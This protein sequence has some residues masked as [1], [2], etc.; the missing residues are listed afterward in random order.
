MNFEASDLAEHS[1]P[2]IS[3]PEHVAQEIRSLRRKQSLSLEELAARSGVSRSMI[4]KI[5]RSEAVPST[6]VLSRLAE[7]LGVTFSRLIATE[8]E[9]EVV[10]IRANR[11]PIL[12]DEETGYLRRCLS[13]VL[14]GRG[15]DWVLNT[16]PPLSKTGDFTAHRRGFSEYVYVL[17]GQLRILVGDRTFDLQTGDSFYFEAD[18]RHAF[19]NPDADECQYFLVIS[20]PRS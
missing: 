16:L 6:T 15:I 7:A 1:N 12:R 2:Q 9:R 8:T 13:P 5:E 10:V 18:A 3:S 20:P 19:E 11:Q 4:S 17:R 14:P